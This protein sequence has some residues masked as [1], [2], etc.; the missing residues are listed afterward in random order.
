MW[1]EPCRGGGPPQRRRNL[2]M[3]LPCAVTPSVSVTRRGRTG[4]GACPAPRS[5]SVYG[6]RSDV[7]NTVRLGGLPEEC[8][9]RTGT[10][11]TSP[12]WGRVQT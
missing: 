4:S 12:W 9:S 2:V 6:V 3:A 5:V 1:C 7:R 8:L 11:G 10:R